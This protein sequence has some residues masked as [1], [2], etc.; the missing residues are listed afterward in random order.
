MP[1]LLLG[2]VGIFPSDRQITLK[3]P[4]NHSQVSVAVNFPPGPIG[5]GF[6]S[7]SAFHLPT[8]YPSRACSGPGLCAWDAWAAADCKP[9]NDT[10]THAASTLNSLFMRP[11][12]GLVG[13][14][15]AR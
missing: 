9:V 15:I 4:S 10:N 12:C 14:F 5:P 1:M 3:R 6:N 13:H 7:P 11:S 8:K 2:P